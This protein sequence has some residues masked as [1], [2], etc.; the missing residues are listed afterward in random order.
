M[1]FLDTITNVALNTD[2]FDAID[3]YVRSTYAKT[4]S[5]ETLKRQFI[6]WSGGLWPGA[7]ALDSNIREAHNRRNAFNVA[8]TDTP[9]ERQSVKA[10]ISRGQT[11]EE[12]RGQTR[13]VDDA[14]NYANA[15][16]ITVGSA[17]RSSVPKGARGTIRRGASGDAVRAW[18]AIIGV[19]TDGK[20]GPGTEAATKKFQAAHG[21]KADGIV[22]TASWSAAL[23]AQSNTSMP[24]S[25]ADVTPV[26]PVNQAASDV[27]IGTVIPAQATT[28]A[29]AKVVEKPLNPVIIADTMKPPTVVK[30]KGFIPKARKYADEHPLSAATIGA[31]AILTILKLFFI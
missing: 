31:G 2:D 15:K 18:Q 24:V 1:G 26:A 17:S 16:G 9:A 10:I 25:V 11:I 27:P 3:R 13:R 20:F 12:N 30:P 14:G 22:G 4:T 23:G 5:A 28:K 6:S 19:A 8:N 29:P 21:L 7:K